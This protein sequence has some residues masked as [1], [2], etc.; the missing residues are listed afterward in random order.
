[1]RA[2][3]TELG[4][5]AAEILGTRAGGA[6]VAA[7]RRS[8]Y[9][10]DE[11]GR[12]VWLGQDASVLPARGIVVAAGLDF[13]RLRAAQR[14]DHCEG[15]LRIEDT[16]LV[17]IAA[18]PPLIWPAAGKPHADWPAGARDMLAQLPL[19]EA[20]GLGALLAGRPLAALL[21]PLHE[22]LA[23]LEQALHWNATHLS[24]TADAGAAA[25]A[26]L[27]AGLGLTPS[28]DDFL[29]GLLGTLR[30]ACPAPA[31][32]LD[33]L[34]AAVM[35]AAPLRTTPISAALLCDLLAGAPPR[36]LVRFWS[37]LFG[38]DRAA[39]A[40]AVAQLRSH[41]ATSP[42][43]FLTGVAAAARIFTASQR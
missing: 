12:L 24:C 34:I 13:A 11:A 14:W 21:L 28:G 31:P 18:Q 38:A 41:G 15:A 9:L 22:P 2:V 10:A 37:A 42:W 23:Q 17:R 20:R 26:L 36:H 40:A 7:F 39:L 5:I 4:P 27:G 25:V 1:M 19:D 16:A 29:G 6:V 3:A 33:Q 32:E 43:D 8:A 35:Q 30:G